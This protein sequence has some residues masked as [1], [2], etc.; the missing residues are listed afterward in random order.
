[1]K[2][3]LLIICTLGIL[4]FVPSLS[5][6]NTDSIPSNQ[7]NC[8]DL[9]ELYKEINKSSQAEQVLIIV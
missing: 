5:F 6:A 9:E 2:K 4:L 8:I 1:M 7:E 3:I